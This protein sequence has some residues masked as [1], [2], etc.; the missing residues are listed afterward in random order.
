MDKYDIHKIEDEHPIIL[1]KYTP[2]IVNLTLSLILLIYMW[3]SL[4]KDFNFLLCCI[5][6]LF[7]AFAVWWLCNQGEL[8]S[9]WITVFAPYVVIGIITIWTVTLQAGNKI[10]L[11]P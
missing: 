5:L 7:W 9:A 6:L 10:N 11:L 4:A 1:S 8:T 3:I 2:L